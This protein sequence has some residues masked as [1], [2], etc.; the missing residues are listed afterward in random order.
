LFSKPRPI[1]KLFFKKK[2]TNNLFL[3]S[4]N[5]LNSKS[6][7]NTQISLTSQFYYE[8]TSEKK[9]NRQK[10]IL[11]I[12]DVILGLQS[13]ETE[14]DFLKFCFLNRE[15]ISY[16]LLYQITALK[17]KKEEDE[18]EI[19]RG[20]KIIG[21]RK[22]ILENIQL[23]DQPVSQSLIVSEKIIKE[24][25]TK[26]Y[27][28][29]E[30]K[31][32]VKNNKLNISSL[33]IVLTAAITA[34]EKKIEFEEDEVSAQTLERIKKIK[35]IIFSD[36]KISFLLAKEFVFIDFFNFE[37]SKSPDVEIGCLDGLKLLICFLEKLPKSSYGTLLEKVSE[38]YGKVLF[39]KFG[40]KKQFLGENVIQ[41]SPKKITTDSRLVNIKDKSI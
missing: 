31:S 22:K 23:I 15:N 35:K 9:L 20:N 29:G 2:S 26:E 8:K 25:L 36:K 21:L 4:Y 16:V 5:S 1:P 27:S 37:E 18:Q 30:L 41:F 28:D 34:W 3:N 19:L 24:I 17:L 40:I 14:K 32:L 33:W 7:K 39:A 13:N 11:P 10:I 38:I 6:H 12:D